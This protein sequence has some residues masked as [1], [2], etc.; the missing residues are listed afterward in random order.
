M[1]STALCYNV[2]ANF[3]N[4]DL[5]VCEWAAEAA[6]YISSYISELEGRYLHYTIFVHMLRVWEFELLVFDMTLWHVIVRSL[7]HIYMNTLFL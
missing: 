5:K 1:Y 3:W 2:P 6:V 4:L 7:P